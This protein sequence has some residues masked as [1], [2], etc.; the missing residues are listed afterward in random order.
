MKKQIIGLLTIIIIL[1]LCLSGCRH[2]GQAELTSSA[3][4]ETTTAAATTTSYFEN[5]MSHT[6]DYPH[7]TK[8]EF[9]SVVKGKTELTFLDFP[10]EKSCVLT[11]G[12]RCECFIIEEKFLLIIGDESMFEVEQGLTAAGGYYCSLGYYENGRMMDSIVTVGRFADFIDVY[13]D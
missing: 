10:A 6:G 13:T 8:E 7:L 5:I 12:T 11:M 9:L 4:D 2:G 1:L 3:A